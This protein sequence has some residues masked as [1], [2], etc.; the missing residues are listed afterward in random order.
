M[1]NDGM[2]NLPQTN[3]DNVD[4]LIIGAGTAGIPCAIEAATAGASVTVIEKADDIGGTLCYSGG[5]MSAAD[6]RL[7]RARG[8][9]DSVEDHYADIV[10][11]GGEP[12]D[13]ALVRRAAK[14][15]PGTIDW[16]DELG[17]PFD[18]SCPALAPEHEYYGVPR[19]Y[20]GPDAGISILE[21]LRPH[22]DK[23]VMDGAI[24][25]ELGSQVV[26]LETEAN[27]VCGAVIETNTGQRFRIRARATVLATG[28]YGANPQMYAQ[29]TPS[30]PPLVTHALETAKGD[31]V[32]LTRKLGTQV[33][34][35]GIYV[36]SLGGFRPETGPGR[37]RPWREGWGLVGSA[38]MRAP[39]EIYVDSSGCRFINEAEAS[40]DRRDDAIRSLDRELFWLV[41]D[42]TALFA[43][44]CLIQ[45]WENED[46]VA[47][48]DAGEFCWRAERIDEL[49]V[50]AGLD[51][52]TL[53][54]TVA[55]YNDSVER[56]SDPLG[57]HAPDYPIK[58]PPYYAFRFQGC[59]GLSWAG[60]KVDAELR[61]LDRDNQPIDGLYAA[62]EVLGMASLS[63]SRTVG[64]MSVTPAL[65]FGR[66]LGQRLP[67]AAKHPA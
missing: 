6:T 27:A 32:T 8:I 51:P 37:I 47:A 53:V 3:A 62:G 49:A 9:E 28:G 56:G 41:F 15:A 44:D 4:V 12:I 21:T 48:A 11:M 17:F 46:I 23:L 55:D 60:L 1:A 26:E 38:R 39:R 16:L 2:T 61:V 34:N 7:G 57:R 13:K 40:N 66:W 50:R 63:G 67:E 36:P 58:T 22:W 33:R 52:T 59:V 24:R 14:L 30:A 18:P 31:A 43:G 65:S 54:K 20:W 29:F 35:T 45:G 64:G 25:V 42:S 5:Q 19:T 10:R